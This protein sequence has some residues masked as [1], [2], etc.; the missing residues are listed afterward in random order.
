MQISCG[1]AVWS[2]PRSFPSRLTQRSVWRVHHD[3]AVAVDD[4]LLGREPIVEERTAL[5]DQ[6]F[7]VTGPGKR[8]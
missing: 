5:G 2:P 4:M 6:S 7:E 8:A 1:V 3:V